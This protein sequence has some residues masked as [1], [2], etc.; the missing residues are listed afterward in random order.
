LWF[1]IVLAVISWMSDHVRVT[2]LDAIEEIVVADGSLRWKLRFVAQ[3]EAAHA[4]QPPAQ[5][6][7]TILPATDRTG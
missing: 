1:P 6:S 4:R 7:A 3:R 2:S 5:L